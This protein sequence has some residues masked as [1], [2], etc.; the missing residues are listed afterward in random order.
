[1]EGG[2]RSSF[3]TEPIYDGVSGKVIRFIFSEILK[4]E[5]VEGESG[6]YKQQ[7]VKVRVITYSCNF[8]ISIYRMFLDV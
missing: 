1:M 4:E 7:L 2:C 3:V 6:K 8:Y 5:T